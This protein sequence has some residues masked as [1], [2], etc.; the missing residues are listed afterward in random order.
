[1]NTVFFAAGD[2]VMEKQFSPLLPPLGE[3]II[4]LIGFLLLA[5]VLMKFVWPAFEKAYA[6]RAEAIEGGIAKAEAAQK[7]AKAALDKYNA[8]LAGARQEAAK[9]RDD[10][11]AEGQRIV[12]EMKA[13][14]HSESDRIIARG[15]ESLQAQ[16]S[17]V[18]H[19]LRSQI[20]TM[21]V[22]LA[23]RIVGESLQDDARTAATIDRF[24][25]ELDRVQ[26]QDAQ[27]A[28][29]AASAAP[30]ATTGPD[31]GALFDDGAG[32]QR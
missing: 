29:P 5:F 23:S 6:Q 21:G 27:Q 12:D 13:Q 4:G 26:A 7:E 22:S 31:Q 3:I 1:M 19:E 17:Q 14:A 8:Q 32:E 18:V 20:G 28:T 10:A 30:A 25:D 2:G 11:R 24:L 15:E 16:R 9:I